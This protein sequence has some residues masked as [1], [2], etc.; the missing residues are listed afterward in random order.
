VYCGLLVRTCIQHIQ[1]VS[2]EDHTYNI[3]VIHDDNISHAR[4]GRHICC[5]MSVII[6]SKRGKTRAV[7][8]VNKAEEIDAKTSFDYHIIEMEIYSKTIN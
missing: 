6:H 3:F 4:P 1:H 2:L 8:M 7:I 5:N